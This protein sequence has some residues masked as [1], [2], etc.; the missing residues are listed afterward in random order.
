[1]PLDHTPHQF[2]VYGGV[3]VDEHVAKGD[4]ARQLGDRGGK[5]RVHLSQP[6]QSLAN[7]LEL[8]LD[9]RAEQLVGKVG[10]WI[11]AP[12]K[13]RNSLGR[14]TR[15]PKLLRRIVPNHA[16]GNNR[17]RCACTRAR[18]YGFSSAGSVS[19]STGRRNRVSSPSRN[20]K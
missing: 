12:G 1:M 6:G 20:P 4:D 8:P 14:P 19:K 16:G 10:R 7:D 3:A 13:A 18:K 5:D 17:C 11:S 9:R 2:I 15:V